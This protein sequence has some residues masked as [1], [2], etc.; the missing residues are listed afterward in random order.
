MDYSLLI[1]IHELGTLTENSVP[2]DEGA[3][4]LP[5]GPGS[6]AEDRVASAGDGLGTISSLWRSRRLS[7]GRPSV[8]D[9]S[10]LTAGGNLSAGDED[11]DDEILFLS[12]TGVAPI[13]GASG[14]MIILTK[15]FEK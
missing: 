11:E 3:N 14:G 1:G 8:A 7:V 2:L 10:I 15:A 9:P 5:G 12:D 6:G 13:I 4:D